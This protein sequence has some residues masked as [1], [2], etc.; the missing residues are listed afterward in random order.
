MALGQRLLWASISSTVDALAAPARESMFQP[1]LPAGQV[2][3]P[4]VE[5]PQVAIRYGPQSRLGAHAYPGPHQV[6]S[7]DDQSAV[8]LLV[9]GHYLPVRVHFR[10]EDL[11]AV[12]E[13]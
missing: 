13:Q 6:Q 12:G 4:Y 11:T 7:S 10:R 9:S 1:L 3:K 5:S 2:R 8:D